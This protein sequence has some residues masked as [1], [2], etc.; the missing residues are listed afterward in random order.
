[1]TLSDVFHQFVGAVSH[2][3]AFWDVVDEIDGSTCVLEPEKPTRAAC[4]RR[5]ALGL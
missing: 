1:M 4:Y 3:Q 5:L 2:W